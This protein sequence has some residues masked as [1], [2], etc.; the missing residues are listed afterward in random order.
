VNCFAWATMWVRPRYGGSS[1]AGVPLAPQRRDH[2]TWRRFLHTQASTILA[3]DFFHVDCAV[4]LRRVYVF[5]VM[6]VG[7]RYVHVLG[8][9]T[10]PD[11]SWTLPVPVPYDV[12]IFKSCKVHRDFHLE[13]G[14]ALYS[15]PKAYLGQ[16]VDVRADS[17]L[18]KVFWHGRLI[19]V[20]PRQRPRRPV[21][22]PRRPARREG[23][24]RDA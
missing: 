4:T 6:E 15:V 20:H 14:K 13:V 9:T 8:V 21:D 1:S 12:P 3:C 16:Q 19:K 5:F 24:L 17:T 7:S 23:R 18:V 10:N 22:R 2:T 11:G